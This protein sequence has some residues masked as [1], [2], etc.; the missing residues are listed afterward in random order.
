M[1]REYYTYLLASKRNGTLYIGVTNDLDRR[2]LEHKHGIGSKFT[3]KYSV[4]ILVYFETYDRIETAIAR[5][6]QG[7]EP[8]LED[9]ADREEQFRLE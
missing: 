1:S 7:L 5:E 8:R 6:K 9:Q 2:T 3:K 4:T